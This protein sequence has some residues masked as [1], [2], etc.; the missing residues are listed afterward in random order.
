MTWQCPLTCNRCPA[1]NS[2]PTRP[3]NIANPALPNQNCKDMLELAKSIN[4]IILTNIKLSHMEEEWI[5]PK[6]LLFNGHKGNNVSH[7][8]PIGLY[9]FKWKMNKINY[10][11]RHAIL[12]SQ[13][14]VALNFF[15]LNESIYKY[16]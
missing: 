5:L 9:Y 10:I 13:F 11:H 14:L 15:E 2:Q 4:K 1:D 8:L 12:V 7:L 3:P 6:C 16:L